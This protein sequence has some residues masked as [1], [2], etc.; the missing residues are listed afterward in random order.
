MKIFSTLLAVLIALVIASISKSDDLETFLDQVAKESAKQEQVTRENIEQVEASLK[1][2]EK[3]LAKV[4][5]E[6]KA[7]APKKKA[8]VRKRPLTE[9]EIRQGFQEFMT[10]PPNKLRVAHDELAEKVAT[11]SHQLDILRKRPAVVIPTLDAFSPR[12]GAIGLIQGRISFTVA[13]IAADGSIHAIPERGDDSGNRVIIRGLASAG[14][15]DGS[16]FVPSNIMRVTGTEAYTTVAGAR[17]TVFVLEP[18]GIG[19]D[20]FEEEITKRMAE[21]KKAKEAKEKP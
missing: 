13:Q 21:I 7:K 4:V 1:A 6:I 10:T 14:L 18:L 2:A 12:V 17:A 9:D 16:R 5:K 8:V 3:S 20:R 15:A 11:Y 19:K